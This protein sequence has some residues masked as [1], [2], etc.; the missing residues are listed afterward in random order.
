MKSA[1]VGCGIIADMHAK[2]ISEL[3]VSELV[4][5]CDIVIDRAVR[6]AN[7]YGIEGCKAYQSLED[8][9]DKEKIDVL[10]ICTPHY[11][12]V[13]MAIYAME[14]GIH[15]FMEKPPAISREQFCMLEHAKK[16]VELGICFQNRFNESVRAVKDLL[17][18]GEAGNVCGA[19]AFVTWSR[20]KEYYTES[21]WRGTQ[22]YEGGGVLINQTIHTLDLL[23]HFLGKP[24]LSEASLH[25]HH[26][27][28]MIEV[29]DTLEAYM[30]FEGG[31]VL[32][33]VTNAY[34]SNS[35]VFIELQCDNYTI[36][37]E[38]CE[39]TKLHSNGEREK[40]SYHKGYTM[41]KDYWGTGHKS[42]IK[43]FYQCLI[44]ERRFPIELEDV[45]DTFT[46]MMDIY[47]SAK[48]NR[49]IYFNKEQRLSGFADEID[50]DFDTQIKVLKECNM[51]YMELRSAYGK[52]ISEYSLEE[53]RH[54]KEKLDRAGIKVSAIASPI[55]KISIDEDFEEHFQ[56]FCQVVTLAKLFDTPYI[57]IFS[58]YIPQN[59]VA[60]SYKKAVF[61]RMSRM[62]AYA[63]QHGVI[64]LHE[65][66]KGIYGD[67]AIRCKE[68]MEEFYGEHFKLI[69]DFANFIQCGQ[70]IWEAY[71]LLRPFIS[72]IH[73]KDAKKDTHAVVPAGMGDGQLIDIVKR[74][75]QDHYDGFYS[76][77]PHLFEFKGLQ[78]LERE[79]DKTIMEQDIFDGKSA[80]HIAY[81]AWMEVIEK[82]R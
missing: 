38:D 55:G 42:C 21:G 2:I 37:L 35:P 33:Y 8:M 24:I 7:T 57:R 46:L 81:N 62:I 66:E 31:P 20:S 3:E 75:V 63:K 69:F 52:N 15:V 50:P 34:S 72:Y 19:R 43:E 77:E 59:T 47:Q 80:F 51:S 65:N 67:I 73:V 41:G 16:E 29:E 79:Q 45:K 70:D 40:V 18:S 53:A 58:F 68:L 76:L 36:R 23:V 5:V 30:E 10:H 25:N 39:V 6:L 71:Q 4:A 27:K 14:K 82:S 32:F 1:I 26:L 28:H 17:V 22:A 12:H 11:L 64:L 74:L 48:E 78:Q 49:V 44:E 54:L 56:L 9:C 13:P 61:E 60:E